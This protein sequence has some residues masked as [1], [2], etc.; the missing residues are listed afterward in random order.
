LIAIFLLKAHTFF[1]LLSFSFVI[2]NKTKDKSIGIIAYQK[3]NSLQCH[4]L[5]KHKIIV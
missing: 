3:N 1:L 2:Y 4:R 5:I